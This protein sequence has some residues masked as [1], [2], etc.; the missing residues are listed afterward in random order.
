MEVNAMVKRWIPIGI[1]CLVLIVSAFACS[2]Q[3]V[4]STPAS[5][6][7]PVETTEQ[8][9][10]EVEPREEGLSEEELRAQEREEA[11]QQISENKIYFDFDSFKL[12]EKARQTLQAKA[13]Q[14][15]KFTSLTM[16]IEGHCDERG[17]SEYNLALGQKRAQAAYEYL[18]LL[19]VSGKRMKV[20][21][22]GEE[23]PAVM[24]SNE[25]AWA[26]NRRDEFRINQ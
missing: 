3:T 23:R 17:T 6:T 22:F 12:S 18:V 8:Q 10:M 7:Q 11:I 24:G 13:K 19:G 5:T 16:V 21:S 14:M 25:E 15:K 20:V 4:D 1:L 2:K 26:K 9:T